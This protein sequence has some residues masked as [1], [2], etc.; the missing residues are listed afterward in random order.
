VPDEVRL[1]LG[2]RRGGQDIFAT[3]QPPSQPQALV[4]P[5]STAL[6]PTKLM[7][8]RARFAP[9]E[10]VE[11]AKVRDEHNLDEETHL[12]ELRPGDRV[13]KGDLL[14][15]F[16]SVDVASKK[17]DLVD[18]L[19]QLKLDQEVL[20]RAEKVNG[21]L[22]DVFI[23]NARRNVE[24]DRNAIARAVSNLKT[25]NVPEA[26]IQAVH[27]EAEEIL[28]RKGK[29]DKDVEATWPRVE[30]RAPDDGTIVERNI[31]VHEMVVD[32]TVNLFQIARVD[33]LTVIVNAPEDELPTLN[34]LNAH[35][36]QWTIRTVGAEEGVGIWG[37]IEEIGYIIDPNQHTAVLKGTI[38]NPGGRLRAGQFVSATVNIPPPTDVVEIPTSAVVDDGAQAVVFVQTNAE[39]H[40]YTMRRV[41]LVQRLDKT[42]LVRSTPFDKSEQPTAEELE[43]GMLVKEPLQPGEKLLP[44]GVNELKTAFFDKQQARTGPEGLK[45][46]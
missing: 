23:L 38:S 24:G 27:Q 45:K 39:K 12:R 37:P 10:V 9:A 29:R 35:Q 40:Y 15:V 14:G 34:A 30:L 25:W 2:I 26:D 28:K 6:D 5:G 19:V 42:V 1:A 18:A 11:I 41:E 22:P 21:A 44:T 46:D 4:L 13:R 16:F 8:I 7:R 36:R 32:N 17:N 20:D 33:R 43:L 3:A 31:A